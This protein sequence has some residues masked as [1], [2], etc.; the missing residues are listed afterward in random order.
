MHSLASLKNDGEH[1]VQP[2]PLF[3]PLYSVSITTLAHRGIHLDGISD[4]TS[5]Q[6]QT[7]TANGGGS[8]RVIL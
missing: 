3:T 4:S 1:P 2:S 7:F 5:A 6:A 8:Q